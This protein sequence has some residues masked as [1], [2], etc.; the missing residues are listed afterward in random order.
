[1]AA[2]DLTPQ[3]VE[4]VV[5]LFQVA[6]DAVQLLNTVLKDAGPFIDFVVVPA[7][8]IAADIVLPIIEDALSIVCG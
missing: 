2:T 8:D 4:L 3:E 6:T 1:M 5:F 7:A